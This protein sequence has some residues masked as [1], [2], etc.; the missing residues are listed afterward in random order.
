MPSAWR[1]DEAQE[2]AARRVHDP[3]L[4]RTAPRLSKQALSGKSRRIA[5]ALFRGA[6]TSPPPVSILV[7]TLT[8]ASLLRRSFVAVLLLFPCHS[9]R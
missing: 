4:N 8:A 1:F 5:C 9:S 3:V 7:R 2:V 6:K